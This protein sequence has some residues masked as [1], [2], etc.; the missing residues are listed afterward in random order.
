M[1]PFI[2]FLLVFSCSSYAQYKLKDIPYDFSEVNLKDDKG[3]QGVWFFYDRLDSTVRAMQNFIN[4]TLHGYSEWYWHN[5]VIS[6]KGFYYKGQLDSIF[7]AYWENGEIRAIQ[8]YEK[9]S[10][11]GIS[12]SYDANGKL[13]LKLNYIDNY[14]DSSFS[15][16]FIDSTVAWDKGRPVK[17][18]TIVITR[19][20]I[21]WNK[22]FEIYHNNVIS[23]E[24][25][26]YDDKIFLENYYKNGKLVKRVVYF[27]KKPYGVEKIYY[28]NNKE[29]L[30]KTEFFD[31]KGNI[32]KTTSH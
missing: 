30:F 3:K 19:E 17:I 15:E 18:D 21:K 22:T 1:K 26:F 32:S 7:T 23:K 14:I 31:K 29:K 8:H 5:G 20:Y 2:F 12:T 6:E 4:D 28:Y 9:G 25:K 24:V 16:M 27:R 13:I 10:L 11:S